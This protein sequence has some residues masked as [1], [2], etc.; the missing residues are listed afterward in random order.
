MKRCITVLLLANPLWAGEASYWQCTTSDDDNKQWVMKSIYERAARAKTV[1]ACKK[2]S[3]NPS[4]CKTD[5]EEFNH[6]VSTQ[7]LWQ[8]TALDQNAKPWISQAY[9]QRDDAAIAAK[10]RCQELSSIPDSCYIS[11]STCTNLNHWP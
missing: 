10:M 4:S 2:Q 5:C 11:L 7:P 9:T 1:D 6:G 8:C 3:E